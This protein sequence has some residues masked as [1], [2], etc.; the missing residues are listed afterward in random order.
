LPVYL[1]VKPMFW[2]NS[3]IRTNPAGNQ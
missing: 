3:W 1:F 2:M